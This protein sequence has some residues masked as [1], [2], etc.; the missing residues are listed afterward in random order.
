MAPDSE[1]PQFSLILEYEQGKYKDCILA[2]TDAQTEEQ[3][4]FGPWS[5]CASRFA[6]ATMN[7]LVDVSSLEPLLF[8]NALRLAMRRL[9]PASNYFP[10]NADI[11]A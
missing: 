2:I 1:K 11:C 5:H 8:V 10:L 4:G 6:K 7:D 9:A 3:E